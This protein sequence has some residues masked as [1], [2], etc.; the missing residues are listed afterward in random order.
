MKIGD[1]LDWFNYKCSYCG[2]SA[3]LAHSENPIIV[4]GFSVAVIFDETLPSLPILP[5]AAQR[6]CIR[7]IR[8]LTSPREETKGQEKR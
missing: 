6:S 5:K 1:A 8:T 3:V 4:P 2:T 7:K